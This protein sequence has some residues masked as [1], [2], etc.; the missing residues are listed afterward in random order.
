MTAYVHAS[1]DFEPETNSRY[2]EG[3]PIEGNTDDRM[4][5]YYNGQYRWLWKSNGA[6][7]VVFSNS[8]TWSNFNEIKQAATWKNGVANL[9]D[10]TGI[11]QSD[12]SAGSESL[13][14][15]LH[16]GNDT[17]ESSAPCAHFKKLAFYEKA[18]S[19]TELQALTENN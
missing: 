14:T 3:T 19:T 16:I 15:V 6:N 8:D 12:T 10:S 2:Y 11:S 18:L 17:T 4:L 1:S 5:S 13:F 7:D 9:A